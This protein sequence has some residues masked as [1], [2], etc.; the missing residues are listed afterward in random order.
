MTPRED[1]RFH[2]QAA[3]ACACIGALALG[4]AVLIAWKRPDLGDVAALE[5]GIAA[6]AGALGI[7]YLRQARALDRRG[8]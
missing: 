4:A 8:R 6:A 7:A 3:A 2:R 5:A 1:A